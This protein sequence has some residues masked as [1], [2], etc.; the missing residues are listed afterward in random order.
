M[1]PC[2]PHGW[3]WHVHLCSA[4]PTPG[5]SSASFIQFLQIHPTTVDW[6]PGVRQAHAKEGAVLAATPTAPAPCWWGLQ[7]SGNRKL[8]ETMAQMPNH[9]Y[10]TGG[11]KGPGCTREVAPRD[12]PRLGGSALDPATPPSI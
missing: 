7:S 2:S 3:T 1:C 12:G 6:V 9:C 8:Q 4:S 11:C 5:L 10:S